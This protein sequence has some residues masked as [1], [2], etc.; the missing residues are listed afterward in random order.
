MLLRCPRTNKGVRNTQ[1]YTEGTF[2]SAISNPHIDP[3]H[4]AKCLSSPKQCIAKQLHPCSHVRARSPAQFGFRSLGCLKIHSRAHHGQEFN[5]RCG[6]WPWGCPPPSRSHYRI[7]DA[8][9]LPQQLE[10][11]AATTLL[12]P[13]ELGAG[14]CSGYAC[15]RTAARYENSGHRDPRF[16]C[17]FLMQL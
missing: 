16:S 11:K 17:K 13:R 6:L 12:P 4:L 7:P 9:H 1:G 8:A 10:T 15:P 3:K 5:Q 14:S 2:K